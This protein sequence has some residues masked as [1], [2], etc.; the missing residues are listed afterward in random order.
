MFELYLEVKLKTP[1]LITATKFGESFRALDYIPGSTLRGAL[2]GLMVSD[3]TGVDSKEF[4]D[5]F[6]NGA[7]RFS[8]LYY[9]YSDEKKVHYPLP[10]SRYYCKADKKHLYLDCLKKDIPAECPECGSRVV[11][12]PLS[13]GLK[14]IISMHNAIDFSTQ[15]TEE[16]KLF[17]YELICEGQSFSG[18]I[19]ASEKSYLEKIKV[20][21]DNKSLYL[22]KGNSRGLGEVEIVKKEISENRPTI[23]EI[24][25]GFTLTLLSDAILMKEDGS[26]LRTLTGDYLG[27]G[28]IMPEKAFA[29]TK[30]IALWN[31]AADLPRETVIALVAGSCFFKFK[32]KPSD[33]V[34]K[35]LL[36]L[37]T[38][39][40][41]IRWEQ[42][43]GEIKI[44]DLRHDE[45][46]LPTIKE[47]KPPK[48]KKATIE[49]F[50]E[51][52]LKQF[53]KD[54]DELQRVNRPSALF[55]LIRFANNKDFEAIEKTL[56]E[57]IRR[58]KSIFKKI[59]IYEKRFGEYIKEKI[60]DRCEKDIAIAKAGLLALCRFVQAYHK[61]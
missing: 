8:N 56:D 50:H 33:E 19:K 32:S 4:K 61:D 36:S 3:G 47:E 28:N 34:K 55:E 23:G 5:I 7:V 2:A 25:D 57:Q 54:K 24:K 42:G 52:V 45:A 38:E 30:D 17:S 46:P 37:E 13:L 44:N 59:E 29:R 53:E 1:L 31:S 43:F 48:I 27:I 41:G 9:K 49:E 20:L 15:T 58:N 12:K 18:K 6:I 16:G 51:A 60:L 26:F 39:G 10:L 21:L 11:N 22:G 40:I 14:K 35:K